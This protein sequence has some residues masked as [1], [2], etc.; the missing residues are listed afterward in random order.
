MLLGF[1]CLSLLLTFCDYCL[2]ST[3]VLRCDKYEPTMSFVGEIYPNV[4]MFFNTRSFSCSLVKT[5]MNFVSSFLAS[6]LN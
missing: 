6:F 1:W 5:T 4:I 2:K 3:Y